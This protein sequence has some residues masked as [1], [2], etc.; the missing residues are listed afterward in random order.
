M[1]VLLVQET[2]WINK[3]PFQQNHLM[4]MLSLRGHQVRVIDYEIHWREQRERRVLPRRQVFDKVSRIHSE[5]TVDVIRPGV[6]KMPGIDYLSLLFRHRREIERQ[7]E[8]FSPD[9]I[10]GFHI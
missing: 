3:G 7:V 1:R 4:E 8:E 9:V 2:D 10:V 6:V 5:A